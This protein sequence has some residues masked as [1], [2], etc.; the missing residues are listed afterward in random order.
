[1]QQVGAAGD[2][3]MIRNSIAW[4]QKLELRQADAQ[5]KLDEV[6]A[7]IDKNDGDP[8]VLVAQKAT[9]QNDLSQ[10][11]GDQAAVLAQVK[12]RMVD[13]GVAWTDAPAPPQQPAG[14]APAAASGAQPSPSPGA[15]P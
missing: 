9:L 12:A 14:M 3:P 2:D 8:A 13:L 1:M 5:R 10:N 11:S 4:Y 6:Q 7:R 15:K